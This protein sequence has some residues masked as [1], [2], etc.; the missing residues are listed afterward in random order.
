MRGYDALVHFG[1][2]G[3]LSGAVFMFG[4]DTAGSALPSWMGFLS[5]LGIVL[6][7]LGVA[8]V[9]LGLSVKIPYERRE[10]MALQRGR[11]R[12]LDRK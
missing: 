3:V 7:I 11:T 2:G 12:G 6:V 10:R 5:N 1:M 8:L 4:G 9:T